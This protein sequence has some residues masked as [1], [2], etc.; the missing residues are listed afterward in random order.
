[1]PMIKISLI[2]YCVCDGQHSLSM[3]IVVRREFLD[4]VVVVNL[5][6]VVA[7]VDVIV[8]V[9]SAV[10]VCAACVVLVVVAVAVV[11]VD[12]VVAPAIDVVVVGIVVVVVITIMI[13]L[14]CIESSAS[15]LQPDGS[16][17]VSRL[18]ARRVYA[19]RVQNVG[20]QNQRP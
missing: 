15:L 2:N 14:L 8:V 13:L 6:L 20:L 10:V 18:H 9:A 19:C 12:V 4:K 3:A 5:A 16:L 17:G 11:I 1:M 7:V